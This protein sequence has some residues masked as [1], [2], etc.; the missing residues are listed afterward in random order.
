MRH[1]S[2]SRSQV[3]DLGPACRFRLLRLALH[4]GP[5]AT[6]IFGPYPIL[7][8]PS[9]AGPVS[10]LGRLARD[11][12][13][14]GQERVIAAR[15]HAALLD[16]ADAELHHQNERLE[17]AV[18]R[19]EALDKIRSNFLA[20]VSHELRTPLTSVIG[21]SEMLL[22]GLAGA[23]NG[24]QTEYVRTVMEKG[25]QLLA[26]IQGILDISRIEAGGVTLDRT[27]FDVADPIQS[28]LTTV[29][30]AARRKRLRLETELDS[31]LPQL[32]ADR[33]K[34]RQVLINLVGNAVKFTPEGGRVLVRAELSTLRRTECESDP[35]P[36]AVRIAVSDS[37]IGIPASAMARIF[38]PFFQV[39]GSSTREYGGTGLGLSIVKSFIDAHGGRVWVESAPGSGSTFFFT[40]PLDP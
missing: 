36:S 29:T 9:L 1:S 32:Y 5:A 20:T 3:V 40:L 37:G 25:E 26:I 13:E 27:R 39:D 15:R 18:T 8:E 17:L 30:P 16:D 33:D 22:E 10:H 38:D 28:A 23:L 6:V 2:R 19:L 35:R 31:P 14:A 12:V 7:A 34:V 11:L 24:E 21:Y 4:G